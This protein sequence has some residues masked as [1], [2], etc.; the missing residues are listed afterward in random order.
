M[1]L[2]DNK[3]FEA[4]IVKISLKDDLAF[5]RITT[6]TGITPVIFAD[7][8]S[9]K[10]GDTVYTIRN[11]E[12]VHGTV[13]QD[14]ITGINKRAILKTDIYCVDLLETSIKLSEGDSGSSVLNEAGEFLGLLSAASTR[15]PYMSFAIPSNRIRLEYLKFIRDPFRDKQ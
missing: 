5:L 11:A 10:P 9:V 7:S 13:V 15:E 14:K 3:V 6:D 4:Q 12:P 2:Y 8:G 1:A